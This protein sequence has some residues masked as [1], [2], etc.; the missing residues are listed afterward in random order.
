[1]NSHDPW[2]D[3]DPFETLSDLEEIPRK[4]YSAYT[5]KPFVTCLMCSRPLIEQDVFQIQKIFR[6]EECILE[7]A[8]CRECSETMALEYSEESKLAILTFRENSLQL[9]DD[10]ACDFCAKPRSEFENYT[11]A[12]V[13]RNT[14][15]LTPIQFMC[16]QC[17][18][19]LQELLSEKTRDIH[20]NFIKDHFP[21]VP[22]SKDFHP[23]LV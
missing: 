4:L 9:L 2:D 10:D 7:L 6:R 20:G 5:S 23:T 11:I 16:N 13:C 1:M 12:A 22:T 17:E 18:D 19:K 14:S 3:D 15:I 8:V 21:G